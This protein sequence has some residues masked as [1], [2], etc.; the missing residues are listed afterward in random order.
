MAKGRAVRHLG[1]LEEFFHL[2]VQTTPKWSLLACTGYLHEHTSYT[3]PTLSPSTHIIMSIPELRHV[4]SVCFHFASLAFLLLQPVALY[5]LWCCV[6]QCLP[7][8]SEVSDGVQTRDGPWAPPS[9]KGAQSQ[10][11][12]WLHCL[13]TGP[14]HLPRRPLGPRT[15]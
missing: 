1:F 4:P 8:S 11:S 9:I 10:I 3:L 7:L 2:E 14:C 5:L 12:S 6:P 15:G 13:A